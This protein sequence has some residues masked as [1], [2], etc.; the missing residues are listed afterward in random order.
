MTKC[1]LCETHE[2]KYKYKLVDCK[3]VDICE[4]CGKVL[5]EYKINTKDRLLQLVEMIERVKFD[6]ETNQEPDL[7]RTEKVYKLGGRR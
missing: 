7:N 5:Y 4:L 6:R 3:E 2:A 1:Y